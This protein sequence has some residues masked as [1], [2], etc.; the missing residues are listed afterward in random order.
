[1]RGDQDSNPA[2]EDEEEFQG[3]VDAGPARKPETR[4]FVAIR[5]ND[6]ARLSERA[7]ALTKQLDWASSVALSAQWSCCYF[8]EIQKMQ[9]RQWS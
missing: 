5:I 9:H 6:V 2:S 1:L 8:L 7:N 4:L 3:F